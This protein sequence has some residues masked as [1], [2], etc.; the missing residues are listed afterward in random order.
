MKLH[1]YTLRYLSIGIVIVLTVWVFIFYA[2]MTEEVYDNIDDGLKNTKSEIVKKA[3]NNPSI[4]SIQSF[5]ASGFRITP[6]A[7][8]KYSRKNVFTT[9]MIYMDVDD[10]EEPVRMLTT[11]FEDK[12]GDNFLL[13]IRT[14][15]IEAD[16]LLGDFGIAVGALYLMLIISIFLINYFILRKVVWG[17]F[18]K[19]LDNLKNYTIGKEVITEETKTPIREFADLQLEINKMIRRIENTFEQQKTFVSNAAHESQTPLAI[20]SNKLELMAEKEELSE[21]QMIQIQ[22]IHQTLRRLIKLNKSLL[23]LTKIE[24]KQFVNYQDVN[25]ND[26]IKEIIDDFEE[27][28]EY[29]AVSITVK[30]DK[31]PFIVNM[32]KG[33]SITLVQNLLKNALTHNVQGGEVEV[34]ITE[35][36]FRIS[37]TSLIP[38]PLDENLIYNRF[39]RSTTNEQ[40][41]G[42]GLAL[43]QTIIKVTDNLSIKYHFNDKHCFTVYHT[44]YQG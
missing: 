37:N 11:T 14:S 13:E 20:M 43:V 10:N 19:L 3:Y 16:D 22:S 28:F 17:S 27:F 21:E 8:G 36:Y 5:G 9:E 24:N 4:N 41:T 25:F 29:K 35:H 12:N 39:F 44:D 23:M 32:D 40:S 1:N 26:I 42:L 2:F 7:P 33:L 38:T 6:L 18:Y 15:T 34:E 31:Q 30:E